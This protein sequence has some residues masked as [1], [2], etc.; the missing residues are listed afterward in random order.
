MHIQTRPMEGNWPVGRDRT[1]VSS[2]KWGP[3]R[4]G[5]ADT[6]NVLS[7]EIEKLG[8][9]GAVALFLDLR[10]QDIRLAGAPR[11]N[12]PQPTFPGVGISFE[13]K[14]GSLPFFCDDCRHWR[15]NVRAIA[16]T[17]QRL[18]KAE[19]YGVTKQGEQ[20]TGWK[21]L[22]EASPSSDEAWAVIA[23][24]SGPR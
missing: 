4:A 1:P 16:L 7:A 20:Y 9:S 6:L 5:Y 10:E 24:W 14:H 23:K 15:D 12:A 8:G 22:H 11:A 19:I 3:F 18:R 17:L 2:R 21:A 13:S